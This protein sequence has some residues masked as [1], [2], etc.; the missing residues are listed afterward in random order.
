MHPVRRVLIFLFLALLSSLALPQFTA[1]Q[2]SQD[3]Q[4][5][6]TPRRSAPEPTPKPKAKPSPQEPQ[7]QPQ[8]PLTAPVTEV[9][10]ESSS[11]DSQA[12]FT[13]AP[14]ANEAAPAA[15]EEEVGGVAYDPHRGAEG[16][17][18]RNGDFR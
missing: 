12:E 5:H 4:P 13:P 7:D 17:E 9:R 8:P 18:F 10:G 3:D 14:R 16:V 1:A 2:G 15:A 6:I 11:R